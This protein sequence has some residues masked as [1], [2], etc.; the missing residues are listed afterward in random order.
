VKKFK[1]KRIL[2]FGASNSMNSINKSFAQFAANCFSNA[3]VQ[4]LDL[5]DFEMPIYSI[6]REK[7]NGFP[8]EAIEFKEHIKAAD[9]IVIS[10]AEHNGAY[11]AAFKNIFDWISRIEKD[12]WG[13]KPMLLLA[14]SPGGRGASTV[15][16][17]AVEKF[18]RMNT[19]KILSFSLPSFK[20][21]FTIDTGIVDATLADDFYAKISSIDELL[22]S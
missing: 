18:K 1:M 12:V 8:A 16:N 2:A 6:D 17:L 22:T 9:A 11:T 4:L 20:E 13:N 10:F 21:N 5:N 14:T 15:L 3:E 19:N 7:V